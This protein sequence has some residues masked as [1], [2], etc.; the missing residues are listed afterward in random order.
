MKKVYTIDPG[1]DRACAAT[2]DID[3]DTG[4]YR[5]ALT[6][7]GET[8]H[9]E[10]DAAQIAGG[11]L[12]LLLG[13]RA[14]DI[15]YDERGD[16]WAMLIRGKVYER[17]V[18]DQ[19]KLRMAEATGRVG[20]TSPEL[21]TPMAGRVIAVL[22]EPGQ[23]VERGQGVVI[24]E[25]MKMENELKAHRDGVIGAIEVAAGDTVDVGALLTTIEDP[26]A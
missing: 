5:V 21:K 12:S 17:Q 22:V 15:D 20:A 11:G 23:S 24:V 18:L 8:Q 1:T 9:I 19:R 6:R 25:A 14:Y 10:V 2:I 16:V 7:D 13:G 4:H 26:P 3:P